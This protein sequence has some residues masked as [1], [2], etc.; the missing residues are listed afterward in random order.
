MNHQEWF[1]KFQV[2]ILAEE[3]LE[4]RV[5]ED[6]LHGQIWIREQWSI[7]RYALLKMAIHQLP[8]IERKIVKLIFFED[9]SERE[10]AEKLK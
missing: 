5:A 1:E 7:A 2:K 6:Y 4:Q 10:V 8:S 3:V 9:L